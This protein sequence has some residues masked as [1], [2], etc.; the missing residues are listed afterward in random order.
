MNRGT[1]V[2]VEIQKR[3]RILR[4]LSLKI[5]RVGCCRRDQRHQR[6]NGLDR[7]LEHQAPLGNNMM[8]APCHAPQEFDEVI[9]LAVNL[10][11]RIKA[12][13]RYQNERG[14]F[15]LWRLLNG[16]PNATHDPI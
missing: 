10:F 16:A 14:V 13:V 1:L 15:R 3:S 11:V 5:E 9:T 4:T 6:I 8:S 7:I 12:V 2:P